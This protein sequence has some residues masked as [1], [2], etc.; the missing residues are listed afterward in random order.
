M[1]SGGNSSGTSQEDLLGLEQPR[2][3]VSDEVTITPEERLLIGRFTVQP[4]KPGLMQHGHSGGANG[5][6]EGGDDVFREAEPLLA[7]RTGSRRVS[8]RES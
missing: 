2:S 8:E 5:E 1:E 6:G 4:A 7:S 3:S